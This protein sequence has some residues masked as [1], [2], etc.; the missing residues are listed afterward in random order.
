MEKQVADIIKKILLRDAPE[1]VNKA[2]KKFTT[3]ELLEILKGKELIIK[4]PLKIK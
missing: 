2:I 3:K 1:H 4:I